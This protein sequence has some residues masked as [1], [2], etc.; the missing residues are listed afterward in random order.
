MSDARDVI[1][2]RIRDILPNFVLKH[3]ANVHASTILSALQAAGW[4]ITRTVPSE[5]M[6]A[7]F[8]QTYE[9]VHTR[10]HGL[11]DLLKEP[12]TAMLSAAGEE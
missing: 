4:T 9:K 5:K 7:A 3:E 8:W 2:R 1:A 12:F 10:Q 11:G 6:R